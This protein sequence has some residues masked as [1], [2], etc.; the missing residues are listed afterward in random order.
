MVNPEGVIIGNY[1]C[2]ILGFDYNRQ[3]HEADA[4]LMPEVYNLKKLMFY[5]KKE[6]SNIHFFLDF[7]GHS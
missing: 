1:R 2:G 7:H 6:F 4:K 3:F 5:W